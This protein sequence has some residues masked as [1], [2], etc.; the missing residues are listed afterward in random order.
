MRSEKE[1]RDEVR[2]VRDRGKMLSGFWVAELA[3]AAY[4]LEW[5]LS[6]HDKPPSEDIGS[7]ESAQGRIAASMVKAAEK[8]AAASAKKKAPAEKKPAAPAK[9]KGSLHRVK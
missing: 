1:I 6:K 2:R 8:E 5:A 4:S 7:G 9:S 3:A